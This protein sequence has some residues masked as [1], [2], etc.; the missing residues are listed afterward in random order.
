MALYAFF[1]LVSELA[2]EIATG[3]SMNP[4]QVRVMGAKSSSQEPEKT[5]VLVDL[6]PLHDKFDDIVASLTFQRFWHKQIHIDKSIF[7]DYDVLYVHYPGSQLNTEPLGSLICFTM[8][9]T[10]SILGLPPSPPMAPADIAVINSMPYS[11][12]DNNGSILHPLG[13]ILPDKR[14]KDRLNGSLIAVIIFSTIVGVMICF[15]VAWALIFRYTNRSSQ[16]AQTLQG[17]HSLGRSAGD[18]LFAFIWCVPLVISAQNFRFYEIV[19]SVCSINIQQPCAF[20]LSL[21]TTFGKVK[22]GK[23]SNQ[24]VLGI[25][26]IMFLVGSF[27]AQRYG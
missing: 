24:R 12:G 11:V 1:P 4:S 7:G 25:P 17:K 21:F 20:I 10:H 2:K 15:S 23:L 19:Y 22:V 8:I 16:Q 18:I 5:I 9:L 26:V 13:V 27:D 6:V 3:V 14:H